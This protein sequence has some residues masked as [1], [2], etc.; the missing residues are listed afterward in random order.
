[1]TLPYKGVCA[2]L[3]FE[4]FSTKN[5]GSSHG[6]TGFL[7]YFYRTYSMTTRRLGSVPVE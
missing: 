4:T 6:T 1:M 7:I 3:K 5:P 2:K